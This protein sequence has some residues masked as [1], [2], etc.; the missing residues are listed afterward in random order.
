MNRVETA[1]GSLSQAVSL[2]LNQPQSPLL[3]RV[4]AFLLR[5]VRCPS[6]FNRTHRGSIGIKVGA[7][8]R[9]PAVV[10]GGHVQGGYARLVR[11]NGPGRLQPVDA[12]CSPAFPAR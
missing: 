11:A 9:G 1:S 6:G 2:G 5:P 8:R 10:P 7:N 4:E 12:R 3:T